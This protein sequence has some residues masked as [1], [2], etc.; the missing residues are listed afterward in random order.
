MIRFWSR[1]ARNSFL[2]QIQ[3][4]DRHATQCPQAW[5]HAEATTQAALTRTPP[6]EPAPGMVRV[7]I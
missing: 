5:H 4:G 3:P 1:L 2:D 7:S 6:V